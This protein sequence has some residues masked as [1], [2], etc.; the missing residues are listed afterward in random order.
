MRLD[1]SSRD[2]YCIKS[3]EFIEGIVI[4]HA[5]DIIAY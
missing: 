5:S 1:N 3:L 4:G 2:F